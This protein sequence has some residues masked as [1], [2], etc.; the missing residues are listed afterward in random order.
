MD[1]R[2]ALP[3]PLLYGPNGEVLPSDERSSF[4]REFDAKLR[5][6]GFGSRFD[7]SLERE[8][9]RRD[10][11]RERDKRAAENRASNSLTPVMEDVESNARERAKN[12]VYSFG[13]RS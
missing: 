3:K 5:S 2:I 12:K 9:K 6:G 10:D 11:E 7:E 13:R 8:M 1:D 4:E